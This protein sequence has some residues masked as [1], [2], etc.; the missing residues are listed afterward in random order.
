MIMFGWIILGIVLFILLIF[1]LRGLRLIGSNEVGILTKNMFGK[2]MPEGQIIAHQGEIGL[3]ASTLMPG[4]YWK[5]PIVWSISKIPVV[6]I[7]INS[8]GMVESIDGEPLPKGRV[9]GD[10][11]EC[12]QFKTLKCF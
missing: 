4:L 1:L 10:E 11:V 9:L 12:N 3:Q 2:K 5:L 7:D 8:I 6:T